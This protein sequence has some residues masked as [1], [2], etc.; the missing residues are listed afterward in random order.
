MADTLMCSRRR[1]CAEAYPRRVCRV[2]VDRTVNRRLCG[3]VVGRHTPRAP[4]LDARYGVEVSL[5]IAQVHGPGNRMPEVLGDM[6]KSVRNSGRFVLDQGGDHRFNFIYRRRRRDRNACS[7]GGVKPRSGID[8]CPC[9]VPV[10][11]VACR[12]PD[13]P[14]R[15]QRAP[16]DGHGSGRSPRPSL[17]PA[18][19]RTDSRARALGQLHVSASLPR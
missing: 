15:C 17:R 14:P 9:I 3:Q 10:R 19:R 16:Q 11:Q 4:L 6:F 5:R 7:A 13:L 12:R 1:S 8:A 18:C 2:R